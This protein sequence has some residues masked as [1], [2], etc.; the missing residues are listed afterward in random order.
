MLSTKAHEDD[1]REQISNLGKLQD[2]W[3]DGTGKACDPEELANLAEQLVPPL[4]F[5]RTGAAAIPHRGRE[6]PGRMVDRKLQR[7]P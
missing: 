7:G 4:P 2:G 3:L 5:G 1:I 6:R